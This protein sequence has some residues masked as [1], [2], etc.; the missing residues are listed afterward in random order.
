MAKAKVL[1]STRENKGLRPSDPGPTKMAGVTHANP[2]FAQNTVFTTPTFTI[3]GMIFD[4][5]DSLQSLAGGADAITRVIASACGYHLVDLCHLRAIDCDC[6]FQAMKATEPFSAAELT[7]NSSI[8]KDCLTGSLLMRS[9]R[10][11]VRMCSPCQR[12]KL[13]VSAVMSF[14]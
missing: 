6:C 4:P 1:H 11:W 3:Q 10:N 7:G 5:D 13:P 12:D 9:F 8:V 14:M 2:P